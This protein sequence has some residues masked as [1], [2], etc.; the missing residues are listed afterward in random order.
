M[1]IA[2]I[3]NIQHPQINISYPRK[4]FRFDDFKNQGFSLWA[5][6]YEKENEKKCAL[7]AYSFAVSG[8]NNSCSGVSPQ[9]IEG[10][11]KLIASVVSFC[12]VFPSAFDCK[13]SHS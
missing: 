12:Q 1:K 9:G 11:R 8:Q 7:E 2:E 4:L 10:K 3:S 6:G 5:I 13:F